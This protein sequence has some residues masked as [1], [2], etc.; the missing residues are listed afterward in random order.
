MTAYMDLPQHVQKLVADIMISPDCAIEVRYIDIQW[1]S[2]MSDCGL[3][4]SAFTTSLCFGK[5]P[6]TLS[7]DQQQMRSHLL[8]CIES[9]CITPFPTR[10]GMMRGFYVGFTWAMDP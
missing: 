3:Y 8:S 2:G 9:E 6:A 1:Q 10:N 4:A 5:D 7:F